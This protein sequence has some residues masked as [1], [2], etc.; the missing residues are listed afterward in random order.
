VAINTHDMQRILQ[1]FERGS[2]LSKG[3]IGH[4][5]KHSR[6]DRK[7]LSYKVKAKYSR[8]D[9]GLIRIW[10][11]FAPTPQ[12][13]DFHC[14]DP[15]AHGMPLWLHKRC[16]EL[17]EAEALEYLT[18]E[19]QA[20]VRAR[21]FE[22][23][24][25]VDAKSAERERQTLAKAALDP[26]TRRVLQQYV[27]IVDEDNAPAVVPAPEEYPPVGHHNSHGRR[28]DAAIPTPRGPNT[29]KPKPPKLQ[30]AA[31]PPVA[32]K[33]PKARKTDTDPH[34]RSRGQGKNAANRH[35]GAHHQ[36]AGRPDQRAPRRRRSNLK[37]GEK[38]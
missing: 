9:I 23:I 10:N 13:E 12:W 22:E 3:D 30:P 34:R 17:A 25:N 29:E 28:K 8:E 14:T 33:P 2:R 35:A 38:F 19:D 15:N 27:E 37:F 32:V 6:D 7:R 36:S 16:L 21:L 31:N 24:A 1:D 11:P 18:P 26:N 5:P 4:R 20:Y